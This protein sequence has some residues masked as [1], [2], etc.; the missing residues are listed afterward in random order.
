MLGCICKIL[1]VLSCVAFLVFSKPP[2]V[3]TW[4]SHGEM[5]PLDS[6]A[7]WDRVLLSVSMSWR[8]SGYSNLWKRATG[9][10]PPQLAGRPQ[11]PL[12]LGQD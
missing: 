7:D 2:E 5:E 8:C 3:R 9:K 10:S 4:Y 6:A 12:F 11:D 1:K